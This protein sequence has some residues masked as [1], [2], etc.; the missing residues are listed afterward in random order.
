MRTA[1]QLKR[2]RQAMDRAQLKV[3]KMVSKS[4]KGKVTKAFKD[5]LKHLY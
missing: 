3:E 1:K 5:Q 2:K 4:D